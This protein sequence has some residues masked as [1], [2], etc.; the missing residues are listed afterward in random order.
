MNWLDIVLIAVLV[1]AAFFGMRFGLIR[2][3]LTAAGVF[4]GWLFAGQ[5]SGKVGGLFDDSLSNDTLITVIT[6]AV[7]VVG[8]LVGAAIVAKIIRPLLTVFTLGLSSMVDKLGGLALG[9]VI[10]LAIAG[11]I[12][13]ALGRLT[14]NFEIE[15]VTG[16][17]PVPEQVAGQFAVLEGQLAK[18]EDVRDNLEDALTGSQIVS[19]FIDLTD[20]LPASA[21][22]IVPADFQAALDILEENID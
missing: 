21:L 7:I 16:A 15:S 5:L 22:G 18:V 19:I 20:A 13:I 1:V 2:A 14:Y 8:A 3:A 12:V 4:V 10:G 6:Y 17:V 11:A 9:L